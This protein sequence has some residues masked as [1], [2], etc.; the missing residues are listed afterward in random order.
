[1]LDD[2]PRC[3]SCDE[4]T[5]TLVGCDLPGLALDDVCPLCFDNLA[6]GLAQRLGR[7][8]PTPRKRSGGGGPA[9]WS[10]PPSYRQDVP[11]ER[12]TALRAIARA[13]D[14]V[15]AADD[16]LRAAVAAA[17]DAGCSWSEVGQALG[18]TKQTAQQRF[19]QD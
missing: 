19:R 11:D 10:P 17:R 15:S 3:V 1:M 16:A 18:V 2:L 8:G 9:P 13:L 5:T 6:A 7:A 14:R 4:P 12:T